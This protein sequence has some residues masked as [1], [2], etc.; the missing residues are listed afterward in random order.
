MRRSHINNV[1]IITAIALGIM[2][3]SCSALLLDQTVL[4]QA[5][6]TVAP[7]VAII[8]PVDGY[9]CANIVQV[10]G[11]VNDLTNDGSEGRITQLAFEVPGSLIS[12]SAIPD[13][14]GNFIFQF[15]ADSLG[16]SF[17]VKVNA[18]DWNGN[19]TT[20]G[21]S[22]IR[23]AKSSIPS[24]ITEIS[25]KKV[26]LT[27]EDVPE[28]DSYVIYYTSDGSLPSDSVGQTVLDATSPYTLDSLKNGSLYTFRLK[29]IARAGFVDSQSDY[30]QAV[31]LSTQTLI[32]VTVSGRG[33]ISITWNSI[34][35]TNEFEIHR[36]IGELGGFNFYRKV[37][38]TEYI[39]TGLVDGESYYYRIRPV[40][41]STIL[42]GSAAGVTDGFARG[43]NIEKL[44]AIKLS[45]ADLVWRDE[46]LYAAGYGGVQIL[47]P[48][49]DYYELSRISATFIRKVVAPPESDDIYLA[50][51]SD[52]FLIY[53]T[54][55]PSNPYLRGT[56]KPEG[57]DARAIAIWT[58]PVT[59][60]PSLAYVA[61]YCRNIYCLDISN[62]ASPIPIK[63][64][65]IG[66]TDRGNAATDNSAYDLILSPDGQYLFV[67]NRTDG[68]QIIRT[69]DLDGSS[70]VKV[71]QVILS[72]NGQVFPI[73]GLDLQGNYLYASAGGCG[74]VVIDVTVPVGA[75]E[76]GRTG[77]TS[78]SYIEDIV[79]KGSNAYA[80]NRADGVQI[81]DVADPATPRLRQTIA[82][83][84]GYASTGTYSI[85]LNK[86]AAYAW[87]VRDNGDSGVY[88]V[89]LNIPVDIRL[90]CEL[91]M[92]AAPRGIS[93]AGPYAYVAAGYSGLRIL[94]ITDPANVTEVGSA[95][96]ALEAGK[97]VLAGSYAF[98]T[99][100]G[101]TSG[102]DFGWGN[103]EIFDVSDPATPVRVSSFDSGSSTLSGNVNDIAI[104]GDYAYILVTYSGLEVYDISDPAN[105]ALIE[106]SVLPFSSERISLRD[107]CAIISDWGGGLLIVDIGDP[108]NVALVKSIAESSGRVDDFTMSGSLGLS[109][110][111]FFGFH[112]RDMTNPSTTINYPEKLL[113]FLDDA[114]N[115]NE[116]QD[117]AGG[118]GQYIVISSKDLN[119]GIDVVGH[120]RIYDVANP[121][122]P[123]LVDHIEMDGFIPPEYMSE[124]NYC[125]AIAG[126]VIYALGTD[127]KLRIYDMRP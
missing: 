88:T 123:R 113:E 84:I 91:I 69:S 115:A 58:D 47:L 18:E 104:S 81:I 38:G 22:L 76:L 37:T 64:F 94:D 118:L 36:R 85:F 97:V 12:G 111:G 63:T 27:W 125:V 43:A 4:A 1:I 95:A 116:Y 86:G 57:I 93:F 106:T 90:A 53:N 41:H 99:E 28:T 110:L 60:L 108:Y 107:R 65:P 68:V 54:Q 52:G 23:D 75:V 61:D 6:D 127:G 21:I 72:S 109:S 45:Y 24:F 46:I 102:Q 5:K 13:A 49:L 55:L 67:G 8:S 25:S 80:A 73:Y 19:S 48:E 96:T 33:E 62:P 7:V 126:S 14:A 39:D 105:P 35:A 112:L 31:P 2:L 100:R 124:A 77:Y 78:N 66:T 121:V 103:V 40:E 32:P 98:V 44:D 101:T 29:S 34:P 120:L 122:L 74:L 114:G 92:P 9:A 42:S 16:T 79:V 17:L 89:D 50:A 71:V 70:P 51:G 59:G 15:K 3:A 10:Q 119:T 20:A 56:Y 117:T 11:T 26:V 30:I 87:H 83:P 82:M